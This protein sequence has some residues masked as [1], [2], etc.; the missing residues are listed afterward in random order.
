MRDAFSDYHPVVGFVFFAAVLICGMFILHPVCLAVSLLFAFTYSVM[1]AG[2]RA[3]R[4]ALKYM[5][6]LI[7]LTALINPIFNHQGATILGYLPGGNPFTLES[8]YYGVAA[9]AMLS[10]VLCWFSCFGRVMTSDKLVY[11]FGRAMPALSLIFAMTLRFIPRFR[12]QLRL[13]SEAQCCV[14]RDASHGSVPARLKNALKI[15]SIMVT[16]S[17]ENAIETA[18]S[19][20]SRGYGL[21][22]RTAFSIYR[23]E[24]RDLAALIVILLLVGCV[25]AGSAAGWLTMR[26]FPT[27]SGSGSAL[28]SIGIYFAYT[29]LC[30]MPVAINISED[31]KWKALTSKI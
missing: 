1:Q 25:A 8:V 5:L 29:A 22:G 14:G 26:Y 31:R 3:A 11:L 24:R 13:V 30:A 15:L 7:L 6:P 9:A 20:K 10:G 18:D 19:M 21:P 16:W 4:F 17:L 27:A 12:N 28:A 23:F 2:G